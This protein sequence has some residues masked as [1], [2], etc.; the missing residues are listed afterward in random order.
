NE[1]QSE[2]NDII[3]ETHQQRL[4]TLALADQVEEARWSAPALPNGQTLHDALAILLAWDEWAIAV[5]EVSLLRALPARLTLPA[6]NGD[7]AQAYEARAQTRSA[8]LS[9]NDLLGGLQVA[10]TRLIT[11]AV[12]RGAP[13]W[14]ERRLADLAGLSLFADAQ[15]T[16]MVGDVV[17]WLV[18]RERTL[19]AQISEGLGVSVDLD[20]LRK[21]LA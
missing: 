17:R 14:Q 12:G 3:Q 8:P 5:F 10:A 20:E 11:A 9:K 15:G 18:A 19:D 2:P 6:S 4:I 1:Q 7:E 16:P 13:D 21:R